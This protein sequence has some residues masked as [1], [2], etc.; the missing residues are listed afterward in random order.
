MIKNRELKQI[1][2][3]NTGKENTNSLEL[4]ESVYLNKE[5]IID[6]QLVNKPLKITDTTLRDAH[7]SLLATRMTTKE[8]IPVCEKLD[9][10]G[11]YSMEVWGGATFDSCM[12]YLDEDPWERLRILRKHLPNT[13]LQMLLRGQNILGYKHYSDDVVIEFIKRA[14]ANG[15][16]IIRIFDALN[17]NRNMETAFKAAKSEGTHIQG[18]ICFTISPFHNNDVF[19]KKALEMEQMGA[20]S[21][22]IKDMA[23]LIS[24]YEAYNLTKDIKKV[25]SIPLQLHCHFTSGMGMM[26]YL[27]AAEA[28]IDV[29]DT[30][31]SSLALQTSQPAVEPLVET[32]RGTPRDTGLDLRLAYEIATY[33]KKVR[34]NHKEME[35]NVQDID[36]R[37]LTYQI[38]GGMLSNLAVQLKQQKAEDKYEE[39]LKEIPHVRKELG[40]PPLVTPT[41]QIVGT[42]ATLN[43]IL[44][45]RYKMIPAEVQKYLKGF[46]G[47][48][49]T[50]ID[51]KVI[52]K[53]K[54][55][56]NEIIKCR[57][58]DLLE[59]SIEKVKKEEPYFTENMEDILSYILF[60][61][62][63]RDFLK[64]K[65]VKKYHLGMEILNG[66]NR[67]DEEGYGV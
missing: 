17:D 4:E 58:A 10:I 59:P 31:I 43:V 52:K 35:S 57:P 61:E 3:I 64:K 49:P 62:V 51:L 14:V 7:Q 44:K 25:I 50:A 15:I 54:I 40:Y 46:Y 37:V 56:K 2:N 18:T 47:R 22:C 65:A 67:Y 23:G 45:K 48:P 41:S 19:V 33:F 24:P 30:A 32:L 1:Q 60:P 42:Q 39:V 5:N 9:S 53:A 11:F 6:K 16:D 66:D 8:M 34:E 36:T 13:K 26:A 21:I 63:A 28:G 38:P 55:K 20:D 29:V 12:R 27:K